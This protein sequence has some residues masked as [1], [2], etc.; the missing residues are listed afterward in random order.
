M[1]EKK[2]FD[3]TNI[4]QEKFAFT[5]KDEKL[6]DKKLE[7][8]QMSYFEDVLRRFAKNKSSVVAAVIIALLVLFALIGPF[9]VNQE[10]VDSFATQTILNR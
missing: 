6:H 1:Q 10:Y 3:M 2:I 8:K 7:T 4:P 5:N 9:T